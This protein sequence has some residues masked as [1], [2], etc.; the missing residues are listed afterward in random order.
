MA[1]GTPLGGFLNFNLGDLGVNPQRGCGG[2]APNVKKYLDVV[3][4]DL[5]VFNIFLI[6]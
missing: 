4:R 2:G 1:F 5:L 6:F 3:T